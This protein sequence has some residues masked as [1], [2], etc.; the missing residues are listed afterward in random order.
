[1]SCRSV[2]LENM[3]TLFVYSDHKSLKNLFDQKEL[4]MRQRRWMEFLN[5]YDFEL[6][7]HTG[8]ANVVA[9]A[10]NRKSLQMSLMMI[11]KHHKLWEKF[12]DLKISV[13]LI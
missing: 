10:L 5:D 12:R 6:K 2:C 4:N 13:S 9:N 11:K 1:M 8:K 3:E 7:Y